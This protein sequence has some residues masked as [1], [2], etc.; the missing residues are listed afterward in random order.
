MDELYLA[1]LYSCYILHP[2]LLFS[3][4]SCSITGVTPGTTSRRPFRLTEDSSKLATAHHNA[5]PSAVT[6]PTPYPRANL[7]T[8]WAEESSSATRWSEDSPVF[9]SPQ[10][11]RFDDQLNSPTSPV[12]ASPARVIPAEPSQ[13]TPENSPKS[14]YFRPVSR[15]PTRHSARSSSWRSNSSPPPQR[16]SSPPHQRQSPLPRRKFSHPVPASSPSGPH[17]SFPSPSATSPTQTPSPPVLESASRGPIPISSP[18]LKRYSSRSPSFDSILRSSRS[19]SIEDIHGILKNFDGSVYEQAQGVPSSSEQKTPTKSILKIDSVED[20]TP[21]KSVLKKDPS[22]EAPAARHLPSSSS[23]NEDL[24]R[25]FSDV[26]IDPVPGQGRRSAPEVVR[27]K[28]SHENVFL[29]FADPN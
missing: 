13:G 3:I 14:F 27:A 9:P 20:P 22:Y 17:Q 25:N 21:T 18:T 29:K 16:S 23:S 5:Q 12:R 15:S 28:K 7:G 1:S 6:P 24:A 4:L 8:R 11:R 26:I 2:Q 19:S 10:P